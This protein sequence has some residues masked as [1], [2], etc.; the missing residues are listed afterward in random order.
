MPS[1]PS[2]KAIFESTVAPQSDC[3][4]DKRNDGTLR[5]HP[6]TTIFPT[7]SWIA[8]TSASAVV[9][10]FSAAVIVRAL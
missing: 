9:T 4:G 10:H 5:R 3:P 8:A 6:L 7:P 1:A 2:T